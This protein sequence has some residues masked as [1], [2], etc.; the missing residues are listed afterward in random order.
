MLVFALYGPLQFLDELL[1]LRTLSKYLS[2]VIFLSLGFR[3][4]GNVTLSHDGFK[5]IGQRTGPN[6]WRNRGGLLIAY[7]D[8][9]NTFLCTENLSRC[10]YKLIRKVRSLQ[11]D[12]FA[13][14]TKFPFLHC[15]TSCTLHC[16]P[17]GIIRSMP[18]LC[19]LRI[20]ALCVLPSFFKYD[21]YLMSVSKSLAGCPL[22][23][24]LSL[25]NFN[26]DIRDLRF[27]LSAVLPNLNFLS[28]S[29]IQTDNRSSLLGSL[30]MF[31]ELRHWGVAAPKLLVLQWDVFQETN[32]KYEYFKTGIATNNMYGCFPKMVMLKIA[33]ETTHRS[34]P[35][36][37][38]MM[39]S[40]LPSLCVL[41]FI[42]ISRDTALHV[43]TGLNEKPYCVF[44]SELMVN[45]SQV[46]VC[47]HVSILPTWVSVNLNKSH[48]KSYITGLVTDSYDWD[49]RGRDVITACELVT[50]LCPRTDFEAYRERY[51]TRKYFLTNDVCV[52]TL[53]IR[54]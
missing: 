52:L 7:V 3:Y 1:E 15:L 22:L 54:K 41:T 6:P 35:H 14:I 17:V 20:C 12:T 18:Y 13:S 37:V 4:N 19:A 40:T 27:M 26:A 51:V 23:K 50:R 43:R 21:G 25:C 34:A 46:T 29:N 8:S 49:W 24:T 31:V 10:F 39:F 42:N 33:T 11:L 47:V 36:F 53:Y 38:D 30:D 5:C 2:D 32:G 48:Q 28:L 45:L 9:P 44:T 16:Y